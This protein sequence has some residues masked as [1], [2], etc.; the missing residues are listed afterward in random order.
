MVWE[1]VAVSFAV[2]ASLIVALL[3]ARTRAPDV[4]KV[5]NTSPRRFGRIPQSA[6]APRM[7]SFPHPR[8]AASNQAGAESVGGGGRARGD[9][10]LDE[11]VADVPID[12]LL[13]QEQLLGD[14]LVG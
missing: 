9:V 14:G 12:G 4:V 8:R 7:G 6:T 13:A 3:V 10:D 2:F 11:D 1:L 5:A